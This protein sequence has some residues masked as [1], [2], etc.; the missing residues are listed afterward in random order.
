MNSVVYVLIRGY[1]SNVAET[2]GL[3]SIEVYRKL[4]MVI[5]HSR[6][7]RHVHQTRHTAMGKYSRLAHRQA[8]YIVD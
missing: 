1:R 2:S 6:L 3:V 7:D 8:K 4:R 5:R